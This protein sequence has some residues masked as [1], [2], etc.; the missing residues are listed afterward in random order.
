L[1]LE[2]FDG[3]AAGVELG[4]LRRGVDLYQQLAFLHLI[5]GFDMDL[6]DLPGRLG[7]HIHIAS[8]LQSAQ[9]GDA[10][11]MLPR[12]TVTVAR[13]SRPG[14]CNCQA[15][16]PITG[17][18]HATTSRACRAGR[19]RFMGWFQPGKFGPQLRGADS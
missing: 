11:S 8:R 10:V 2:V 3:V 1:G 5:A 13:L 7:A 17:I 6:A 18:R 12:V 16:M 9:G 14:G 19:G 15:A 4:F